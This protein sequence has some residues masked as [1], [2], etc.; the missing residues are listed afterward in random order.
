MTSTIALQS[1]SRPS[2]ASMMGSISF[3]G[4]WRALSKMSSRH[5]LGVFGQTFSRLC[6]SRFGQSAL[7]ISRHFIRLPLRPYS[8]SAC[9]RDSGPCGRAGASTRTRRACLRCHRRSDKCGAWVSAHKRQQLTRRQGRTTSELK[10]KPGAAASREV[11]NRHLP[12]N[13]EAALAMLQEAQGLLL[14]HDRD[15]LRV[16]G[17]MPKKEGRSSY[18]GASSGSW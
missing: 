6:A 1:R 4:R 13:R 7:S 10:I 14:S 15:A 17:D 2:I 16:A 3:Q 12:D 11:A 18:P 9:G 8:R 5:R